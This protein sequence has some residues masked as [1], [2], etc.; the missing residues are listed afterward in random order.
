MPMLRRSIQLGRSPCPYWPDQDV[1]HWTKILG[2]LYC[3]YG[4]VINL[5]GEGHLETDGWGVG[6]VLEMPKSP[7]L[8]FVR[9]IAVPISQLA[10]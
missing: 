6:G 7:S 2:L 1:Q 5:S 9:G 4:T 10:L 8:R 3:G